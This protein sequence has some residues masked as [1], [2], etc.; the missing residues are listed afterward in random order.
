[1]LRTTSGWLPGTGGRT[2]RVQYTFPSVFGLRKPTFGG[3]AVTMGTSARRNQ[4]MVGA[5][6]PAVGHPAHQTTWFVLPRRRTFGRAGFRASG[7]RHRP[8][9]DLR[10]AAALIEG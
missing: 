4:A 10:F 7:G 5:G 3:I 1:M 6:S 9:A 8:G 2:A